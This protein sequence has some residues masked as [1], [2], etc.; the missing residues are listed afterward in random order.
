[1]YRLPTEAQRNTLA[2]PAR[3]RGTALVTGPVL[4]CMVGAKITRRT[5][6]KAVG[7]RT[8]SACSTCMGTSGSGCGA[9]WFDSGYYATSPL[10]D[11]WGADNGLGPCASRR[12]LEFQ[13]EALA[14][15]LV[16]SAATRA[17][18]L[19]TTGSAWPQFRWNRRLRKQG[20]EAKSGAC[21]GTGATLDSAGESSPRIVPSVKTW[22]LTPQAKPLR[23]ELEQPLTDEVK[24]RARRRLG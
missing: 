18:G 16:G 19:A 7:C 1:M 20:L 13:R 17:S 2:E 10:E 21:L 24:E 22:D 9:D 8:P 23:S 11:S 3:Q 4:V 6:R 5:A 14:D 12:C 15:W